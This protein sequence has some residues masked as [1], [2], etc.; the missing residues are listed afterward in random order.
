M[1]FL[2]SCLFPTLSVPQEDLLGQSDLILFS[3]G[4]DLGWDHMNKWLLWTIP[5]SEST[6]LTGWRNQSEKYQRKQTSL[7]SS[8]VITMYNLLQQQW[9]IY[10]FICCAA[11]HSRKSTQI[12]KWIRLFTITAKPFR[13]FI[14]AEVLH[15]ILKHY[16]VHDWVKYKQWV[17]IQH[18]PNT[19]MWLGL[20]I[21]FSLYSL[22]FLSNPIR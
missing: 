6:E 2:S 3:Q 17:S 21:Q 4:P 14:P 1:C 15:Y 22:H 8:T 13:A 16:K 20:Q 7:C 18:W 5:L 11:D 12:G 19:F 9:V 10:K